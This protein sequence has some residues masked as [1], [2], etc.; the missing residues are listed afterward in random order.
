MAICAYLTAGLFNDSTVGIAS[1]FWVLLGLGFVCNE[2][3]KR[4]QINIHKADARS[5]K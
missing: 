5:T 4:N 1:I 3:N 2:I